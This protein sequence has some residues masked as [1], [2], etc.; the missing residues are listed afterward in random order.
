MKV[1]AIVQARCNSTRFPNKILKSLGKKKTVIQVLLQ[2]LSRAKLID[3]IVVATTKSK[4]DDILVK[5]VKNLKNVTF[6]GSENDVLDRFYEVSKIYK[7]KNI[8]RITSDCPFIDP[9]LIDD[10]I[11]CHL[12]NDYEI[13]SNSNI[14]TF[15]DGLDAEIFT[16]KSLDHA[17]VNS[18][19]KHDREHVTTYIKRN[20]SVYNFKDEKDYSNLRLTI[21]EPDDLKVLRKIFKYFKYTSKFSYDDIL[22]LYKKKPEI[23]KGNAHIIRDEGSK[24]TKGQKLWKRA[25]NIIPSGNMFLSKNSETFLPKFWPSYY[26]KAK[27]VNI[28]D[29]D[30]K[31]FIDTSLMSVGTNILGY[32]NKRVDNKVK[33]AINKSVMS[34]LN[35]PEEVELCE[36]LISMHKWADMVRL[37]RTG[38][39]INAISIR[40][41]RAYTGKDKVA[42]CGYHG[43]HDWYLST[44]LADNKNLNKHL[45]S[46]LQTDGVPKV[47]K[48][49]VF[50]F[51]Y[52]NI[53]QLKKIL[54]LNKDIGT[55]KIEVSRNEK[56]NVN[57]LKEIRKI[58]SKNNIVLIFDECTSGFRETFGG[59]HLKY[60][61]EPDLATFGKA[62]GNGYAI[63]ALLGKKDIMNKSL[64][65]FISSTFWSERVGPVAALE[66]LKIMEES[67]SWK[68]ITKTGTDIKLKWSQLIKKYKINAEVKGLSSMP[69]ILFNENDLIYK[70]LITQEMLKKNFL[71]SNSLYVSIEHTDK[72]LK[73]Y[74]LN[75]EEVFKK[76]EI[77]N[78]ENNP[79]K[80]LEGS[81][82]K[83]NISRMN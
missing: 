21:D 72:I 7:P 62:L 28:W 64:D 9:S 52:N 83:S 50:Q 27:G 53:N 82:C 32:A 56:V 24:I 1:L 78:R 12:K 6:R 59:L 36:K 45:L 26:S 74:F 41:S 5:Y 37:A 49:S 22:H 75:L 46:N 30:N 31:K 15:A 67:K 35:C 51:S 60:G 68:K 70:T 11:S 42:I 44:N 39:E 20:N 63:T 79:N 33:E 8:L 17:W 29:L 55:I 18:K 14:I 54:S 76:I 58:A 25:K 77:S 2:R 19:L 40:L 71:A 61:V 10:I 38:G 48:N 16:S 23:F 66:T 3:K 47:L 80:Y 34:T 4:S 73:R 43:W 65:S 69:I 57:F 81:V 13:S